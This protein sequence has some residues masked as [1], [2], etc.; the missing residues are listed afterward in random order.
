MLMLENDKILYD[1]LVLKGMARSKCFDW[2]KTAAQTLDIYEKI[3]LS[4]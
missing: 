1:T 3:Y 2:N 4:I